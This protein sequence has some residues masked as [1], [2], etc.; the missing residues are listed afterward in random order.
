M[1][2]GNIF[3]VFAVI[4]LVALDDLFEGQAVHL[5]GM[6]DDGCQPASHEDF[7]KTFGVHGEI[8]ERDKAAEGLAEDG[9]RL[10]LQRKRGRDVLPDGLEVT[11]I[12]IGPEEF[13]VVS[14]PLRIAE[15][16]DVPG[17]DGS[18]ESYAAVV[19]KDDLIATIYQVSGDGMVLRLT[20]AESR[21]AFKVGNKGDSGYRFKLGSGPRDNA[22]FMLPD[23]AGE[24]GDFASRRD[25]IIERYPE[26][27]FRDEELS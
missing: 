18:A 17:V 3:R 7:P 16:E 21:A 1:D 5:V 20:I 11:D 12:V 25:G 14:L 15:A 10:Q 24:E 22:W 26:E 27:V 8:A 4:C 23:G 2:A 6:P 13:E 9:P 19:K